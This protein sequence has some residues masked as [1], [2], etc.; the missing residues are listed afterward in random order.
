MSASLVPCLLDA[1]RLVSF[2]EVVNTEWGLYVG[3][4]F[5]A[6]QYNVF[7]GWSGIGTPDAPLTGSY[8][9]PGSAALRNMG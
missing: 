7:G 9:S 3:A 5:C 6:A 2:V 8:L 4:G 1:A